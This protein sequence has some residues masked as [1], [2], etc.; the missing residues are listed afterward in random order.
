MN[1]IESEPITETTIYRFQVTCFVLQDRIAATRKHVAIIFW[2]FRFSTD[3]DRLTI[4]DIQPEDEGV[5]VCRA[6]QGDM[7]DMSV[8]AGCLV[9]QGEPI[10]LTVHIMYN[11]ILDSI[12]EHRS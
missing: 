12:I 11:I 3:T 1:K 10:I 7:P 5:Y 2:L 9:V 4:S 6:T 8:I